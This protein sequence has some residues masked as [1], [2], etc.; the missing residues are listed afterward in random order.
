MWDSTLRTQLS[1]TWFNRLPLKPPHQTQ[2]KSL[3][4]ERTQNKT[5]DRPFLPAHSISKLRTLRG[6]ILCHSPS[7]GWLT[8][9]FH[10]T[11]TSYWHSDTWERN[12]VKTRLM[13]VAVTCSNLLIY[14]F[15]IFT[16]PGY[17]ESVCPSLLSSLS[18]YF[19]LGSSIQQQPTTSLS[20]MNLSSR[21]HAA[22]LTC[23]IGSSKQRP[24]HITSFR[25]F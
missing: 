12:T 23:F 17:F 14:C 19:P 4:K 15:Y 21:A 25:N 20:T 6:A 2:N 11:S 24:P 1:T 10:A 18:L 7:A 9:W 3:N 13:S 5:A 16:F 22:N 8:M